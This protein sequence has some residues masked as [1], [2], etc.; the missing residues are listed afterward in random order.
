MVALLL[1]AKQNRSECIFQIAYLR[2]N[3]YAKIKIDEKEYD[4]PS[5]VLSHLRNIRK[6]T[7]LTSQPEIIVFDD[8]FRDRVNYLD[9]LN[10]FINLNSKKQ[11]SILFLDPD[12]GLEPF[13]G[14]SHKHVLE[15]EL[16]EIWE[17]MPPHWI[18]V[19]YQH[20]INRSGEE[21]IE[22]KRKQFAESINVPLQNA[23]IACGFEIAN[24]VVFFFAVKK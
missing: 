9:S 7:E 12:T 13:G 19:F 11:Q 21:W 8:E 23:K 5:Q 4:I 6:I 22:P 10:K 17:E 2:K 1:I 15:K 18:L 24:D 14:A 16:K 20:K 3:E